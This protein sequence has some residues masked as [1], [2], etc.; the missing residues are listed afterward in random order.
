MNKRKIHTDG[1]YDTNDQSP[2]GTR[3]QIVTPDAP[4]GKN[5]ESH[6]SEKSEETGGGEIDPDVRKTHC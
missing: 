2:S 6:T 5:K 3:S 1:H 4:L